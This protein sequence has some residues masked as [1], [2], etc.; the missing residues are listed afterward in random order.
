MMV[1]P[2]QGA[3]ETYCVDVMYTIEKVIMNSAS[4]EED[5][6]YNPECRAFL[7]LPHVQ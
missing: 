1:Y 6:D 7:S 2:V 5:E 3:N 4:E